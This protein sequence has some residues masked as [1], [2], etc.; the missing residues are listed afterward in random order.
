MTS[1]HSDSISG[2]CVAITGGATGIG[3]ALAKELG[4]RGANIMLMEP[5]EA[6]LAEAVAQLNAAGIAAGFTVGD[7]RRDEDLAAFV[8]ACR[9]RFGRAD[10]VI[11]NAGV[12]GGALAKGHKADLAEARALFDVNFWGVWATIQHFWNDWRAESETPAPAS[13]YAVASE[14]ALFNAFPFGGGAYVASKH[15]V[16]GLI[17]TLHRDTPDWLRVGTIFPGWVQSE[18][19][20]LNQ[21]VPAAMPAEDYAAII[22]PQLI[23]GEPWVVSHG[24]NLVRFDERYGEMRAAFDRFAPRREGD[25]RYDVQNYFAQMLAQRAQG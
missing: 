19:S 3:F 12:G 2:K 7:V 5:R 24:Y 8:A 9:A 10:M 11:A 22:A 20:E 25:E 17:A 13:I 16:H 14:N 6:R 1:Q 21:N 18:I 23:A 15:A 4:G